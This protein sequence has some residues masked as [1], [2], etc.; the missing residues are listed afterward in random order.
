MTI[1][2]PDPEELEPELLEEPEELEEL[3]EP[4]ELE[5][6]EEPELLEELEPELLEEPEELEE[7]ELLEEL[8]PELLEEPEE[9]LEELELLSECSGSEYSS[10]RPPRPLMPIATVSESMFASSRASLL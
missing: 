6:L 1:S 10:W 9:L 4:E 5:E 2:Q 3:E 8:E 7:L